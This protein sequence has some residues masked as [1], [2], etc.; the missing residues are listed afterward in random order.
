MVLLPGRSPICSA[1]VEDE[2]VVGAVVAEAQAVVASV[3][4]EAAALVAAE[5][6]EA[7]KKLYIDKR[8]FHVLKGSFFYDVLKNY[9]GYL[10]ARSIPNQKR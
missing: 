6:A 9:K 5:Q 2:A 8:S 3:V 10:Y 7:G 1:A 4:S